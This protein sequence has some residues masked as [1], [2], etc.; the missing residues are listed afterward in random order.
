MGLFSN[1]Y[2]LFSSSMWDQKST[3]AYYNCYSFRP[4]P[5][6]LLRLNWVKLDY[7]K[8]KLLTI[9]FTEGVILQ[10]LA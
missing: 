2:W 9:D 4:S 10:P 7:R 8:A 1:Q 6:I 5:V 3:K